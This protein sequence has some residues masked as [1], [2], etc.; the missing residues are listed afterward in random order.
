MTAPSRGRS[1]RRR[2]GRWSHLLVVVLG[3]GLFGGIY[4]VA[5]PSSRAVNSSAEQSQEVREGRELYVTGCVTCHGSNAQGVTNRGPSLI[6][7]GAASV[8]FQVGTGRMPLARQEAQAPRKQ[9]IYTAAEV[10]QLAAYIKS[11]GGGPQVPPGNLSDGDIA[12]GG[13]LFRLNCAQCHNF[14][15]A[16][17]A[18]SKGKYAPSLAESTDR[19]IYAAMLSGPQNMPVF[20]DNQITP[21]EKEA[22][23]SYINYLQEDTQPGGNSLGR[24]GPVPEGLVVWLVGIGA[25]LVVILWIGAKS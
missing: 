24:L 23:I 17:G 8:E 19:Q 18:L 22:I 1:T 13:R 3:L 25:L 9:P 10:D 11:V 21:E 14:A 4:S 12:E 16:G 5:A 2:P 6:G 15:G 20:G 7:V